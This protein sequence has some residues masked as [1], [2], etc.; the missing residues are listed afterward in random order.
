MLGPRV[1]QHDTMR[2]HLPQEVRAAS[3]AIKG[4]LWTGTTRRV[5]VDTAGSE[6]M[7]AR[8]NLKDNIRSQAKSHAYRC[9]AEISSLDNHPTMHWSS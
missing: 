8:L 5:V 6:S 4:V 7:H 1:L 9:K 2:H 3:L